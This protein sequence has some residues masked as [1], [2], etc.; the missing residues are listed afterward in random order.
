MSRFRVLLVL[1]AL[2]L[3]AAIVAACGSGSEDPQQVLDSATFEGVESGD[4][5]L[6]LQ[7]ESEGRRGGSL[8]LSI[9]G[10][11]QAEGVEATAKVGGTA[12]GKPVDFEGGLTLLAKRGF[13]NYQGTEY[14]IDPG[15][16]SFAKPL[17]FPALSEKGGAELAA[18]RHAATGIERGDLVGNLTSAGSA[19]VA[20]V[21]TTKLSG[22][23]DVPAAVEAL[24]GLAED[25]G[26]GVQFEAL[27]PF[28]RYKVRLLGDE[29][30][31][32]AEKARVEIYVG[33]DDIVRKV[34]GEFTGDPGGG[35][36][37][38]AVHFD[39][40]LS[41]VNANQ[42]IEIPSGAKPVTVLFGKLGVNPFE[43]L[44]WSR[45]GEGVRSLGEKVAADAFP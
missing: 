34:S 4:F 32:S 42:K 18:C 44:S 28:P 35:R 23:L 25:P 17:F 33:D 16:Y 2:C 5:D 36:E 9:S 3:A 21:E 39:F 41:G 20:G 10:R 13:V 7:I 45:G 22:E 24:I 43:F 11:A 37:P 26:C 29:L 15:N 8:D 38:V 19:E 31:E 40:T 14:E 1:I 6:S 27:S 30:S 12:Q